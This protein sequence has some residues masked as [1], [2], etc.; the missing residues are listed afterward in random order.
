MPLATLNLTGCKGITD[1]T[2]LANLK[3]TALRLPAQQVTGM[4]ALRKMASLTTINGVNAEEFW[5]KR[6]NPK[7]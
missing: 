4:D 6:D 5:E 1:L 2:P 7:K 3:L